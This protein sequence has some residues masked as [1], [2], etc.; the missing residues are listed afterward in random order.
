MHPQGI[1]CREIGGLWLLE[2][3][4]DLLAD[5]TIRITFTAQIK[6][7]TEDQTAIINEARLA[8]QNDDQTVT[9]RSHS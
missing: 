6:P 2:G 1:Q 5:D 4:F 7:D 9:V 3:D 8:V